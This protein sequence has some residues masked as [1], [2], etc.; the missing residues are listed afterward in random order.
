MPLGSTSSS[1]AFVRSEVVKLFLTL[2]HFRMSLMNRKMGTWVLSQW[3]FLHSFGLW[4]VSFFFTT[5]ICPLPGMGTQISAVLC[6]MKQNPDCLI[7]EPKR[8][9]GPSP[10]S[11][12]PKWERMSDEVMLGRREQLLSV[13]LNWRFW[14]EGF[15]YSCEVKLTQR[16]T[17]VCFHN[18]LILAHLG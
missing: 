5:P 1:L 6:E 14:W 10:S 11:W 9:R 4:H 16:K 2:N 3:A 18:N 15:A 17:L 8:R 12:R 13:E 7:R